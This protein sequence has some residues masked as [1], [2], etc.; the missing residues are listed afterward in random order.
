MNIKGK[1]GIPNLSDL[2]RISHENE[3]CVKGFD[4]GFQMSP[5]NPSETATA[6]GFW[7]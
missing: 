7:L 4:L 2:S 5:P 1:Y 3:I 6:Q